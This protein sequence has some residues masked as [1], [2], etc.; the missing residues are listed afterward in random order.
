MHLEHGCAENVCQLQLLLKTDL[1]QKNSRPLSPKSNC[2]L[3]FFHKRV[4]SQALKSIVDAICGLV[5]KIWTK[6]S[7]SQKPTSVSAELK[8][9]LKSQEIFF[10]LSSLFKTDSLQEDKFIAV[11][12]KQIRVNHVKTASSEILVPVIAACYF[13][14]RSKQY[15]QQYKCY[16]FLLPCTDVTL[17]PLR[18]KA[19]FIQGS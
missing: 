16:H 17:A 7:S 8:V 6:P 11:D 18:G 4:A 5:S 15:S 2:K 13:A 3:M 10:E 12:V 9:S 1:V 14:H 19:M